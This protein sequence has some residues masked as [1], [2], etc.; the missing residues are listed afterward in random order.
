MEF[1]ESCEASAT[2]C[3]PLPASPGVEQGGAEHTQQ[4][5]D[6]EEA[7]QARPVFL[8]FRFRREPLT[9]T[10]PEDGFANAKGNPSPD[11][12]ILRVVEP[13]V[14]VGGVET[15]DLDPEE[16]G[17]EIVALLK[18]RVPLKSPSGHS[19]NIN[20]INNGAARWGIEGRK[21]SGSRG[22]EFDVRGGGEKGL[23]RPKAGRREQEEE[24]GHDE[25]EEEGEGGAV[26]DNA[27][28]ED[29]PDGSFDVIDGDE[30]AEVILA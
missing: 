18:G 17:Q 6:E 24:A 15:I 29:D 16:D 4:Q 28:V 13:G 27:G 1:S 7:R 10:S 22:G 12:G 21:R 2:D 23:K 9:K 30:D 5:E 8:T 20:N 26:G 14:L 25:G 3:H 11:A 19:I